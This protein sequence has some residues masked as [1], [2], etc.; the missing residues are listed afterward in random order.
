MKNQIVGKLLGV[1]NTLGEIDV[2]GKKNLKTMT[3]CIEFLEGMA[4]ELQNEKTADKGVVNNERD[5]DVSD[6]H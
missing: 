6:K 1:A 3:A 2:H 4:A 5:P